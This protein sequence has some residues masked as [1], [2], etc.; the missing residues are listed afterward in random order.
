MIE[1]YFGLV[2]LLAMKAVFFIELR[3]FEKTVAKSLEDGLGY[4]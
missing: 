4:L 2:Y 1:L 3:E